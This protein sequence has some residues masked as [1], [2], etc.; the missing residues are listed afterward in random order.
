MN[1]QALIKLSATFLFF[2]AFLSTF[3]AAF[4]ADSHHHQRVNDVDFYLAVI[5]AEITQGSPGM[6]AKFKNHETRYHI[7]VSLFDSRSGNRI[8]DAEVQASV[9]TLGGMAEQNK[10]LEPMLIMDTSSYGNY[11]LMSE[12]GKYRLRFKM[13]T[14]THKY[15]S[16][17]E[18]FFDKP[19]D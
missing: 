10:N 4:A 3:S 9:S 16:T 14:P 12:P 2:T 18:F 5:P 8:T 6:Q 11:F 17:A 13:L 19:K 7:L 1:D 15:E